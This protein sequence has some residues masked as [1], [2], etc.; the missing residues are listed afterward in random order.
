MNVV[1]AGSTGYAGQQLSTLLS[2]HPK[3]SHLYLSSG[4]Q[5]D[6]SFDEIY[7]HTKSR[8]QTT[9]CDSAVVLTPEF[10]MSHQIDVCFL[11]L[12][13]GESTALVPKLMNTKAVLIDLGSDFRLDDASLYEAWHGKT[14]SEAYLK[15]GIYGLSEWNREHIKT[16]K[17]I[18]N[19][20][21]Y[22]TAT[23]L[24]TMP[25]IAND[26]STDNLIFVDAKS[27]ISGSGRQASIGSLYAEAAENVKPYKTGVHQ[28]TPEIEETLKAVS[29][30]KM[31]LQ[32]LF[33]PSVV[34]MTR[35]LISTAYFKLRQIVTLDAVKQAFETAYADETFIR[36]MTSAP[37]TKNVRGSNFADLWYHFDE[38][39]HSLTV[40]CAIDNLVKGAS[41]QAIQNMNIRFGWSETLGL[42]LMPL[43]P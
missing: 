6:R 35:G 40:M 27:G 29:P 4:R 41:G 16:A 34:P 38:R 9:L 24:A 31:D 28:H 42:E 8:V 18:A 2:A 12:P 25:V 22:A 39:T 36:L 21:C 26:L 37:A 3:V 32:V 30:N 20:G 1:V 17:L 7:P 15:E 10:F 14:P 23:L 33:S 13:H 5:A 43:Y 19:P 11:A